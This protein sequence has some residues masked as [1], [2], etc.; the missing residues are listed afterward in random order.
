MRCSVLTVLALALLSATLPAQPA[1]YA[2]RGVRA[3]L[4]NYNAVH[5][6][7][8]LAEFAARRFVLID[9]A[10]SADIPMLRAIAPDIPILRYRDMV[11]VYPSLPEFDAVDRDE[12]AFMH[13]TE[14]SG[15]SVAISGDTAT[16]AWTP[17]RRSLPVKGYRLRSS[18]DSLGSAHALVDSLIT[19]VPLRVRLPKSTVFLRVDAELEDGSL[20]NYGFPVRWYNAQTPMVV[21]PSAVGESRSATA[22]ENHIEIRTSGSMRPDSVIVVADLDRSNTLNYSQ[23]R[24]PASWNGESWVCDFSVDI[25]GL[26]SNCGYEF[27]AETW[28]GGRRTV[29]PSQGKW[30]TNVNNRVKNDTYGFYVMNVGS[31]TWRQA[32]IAQI[33]L[34]FSRQGYSG[35]FEDDTWYRIEN[36]GGDSYPP[37]PYDQLEWRANLYGMLDSIRAAIAPR[38]AYF[39]GLYTDVSDSLLAHT[40]GGM[41]EGFAY[42]HWSG[43]VRGASW[44]N[45]CNRGLS[46][47]HVYRKTWMSLGGAPFDDISG[48]LYT[49]A[50]YLMVADSLSMFA[51]ATSYQE[52]SHFPEFDI[53]LGAPLESATLDVDTLAQV[54]GSGRYHRRE[55]EHGTV[56][57]NAGTTPVV[58]PD[59]RARI[60]ITALGGIT[61][62]GGRIEAIHES[63]TLAS[64]TARIYLNMDP[65]ETLASPV[66]DSTRVEPERIPSDGTT[67]CTIRVLAHDASAP[68][69]RSAAALPL[70]VVCDAGAIGGP[71]E[72]VLLPAS[73]GSPERPVWF[74]AAFTIP[75]G[76]PP[77]S[78]RLPVSV[79]AATG[80]VTIGYVTVSI[81]SGDPGNL[82]MNYSFEI[83]DNDDDVPDFWRGYSKGFDYDISGMH[84]RSGS[85]S[86]HVFNDSLT[87]FRGVYVRV[88]LK[89]DSAQA[90]EISGWSKCID[91]SGNADN[92]YALYVDSRYMDGTSLYGQCARFST[93]TH[94]WEYSSHVIH[95]EKPIDYCSVYV[96]F[97]HHTGETWFDQLALRRYDETSDIEIN[98]PET[99]QIE[100]YPNPARDVLN[101]RLRPASHA[102]RRI[103]LYDHL[104]RRC[105]EK[106]LEAITGVEHVSVFPL[107]ALPAGVYHLFV[108][109]RPARTVVVMR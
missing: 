27:T 100:A 48:R 17:D 45:S 66:I 88:D 108:D 4:V 107:T 34:A 37:V 61:T 80:L 105:V 8:F 54:N 53:P 3:Y 69:W 73:P 23:E 89:Q 6:D 98:G 67:P 38:P 50:S 44:R 49:L 78:A 46:A 14:P 9:E 83:D 12:A 55:F 29:Y 22:V 64:G 35:L 24:V 99:P 11:A 13:S 7:R 77:D 92:D 25:T 26:R 21:W 32:T 41:T 20:L 97:R 106:E 60:S 62:D 51:N 90:L 39:N 18:L 40:E 81:E 42:T 86:V 75:V 96:L 10:G 93:G 31:S 103:A 87:D 56:V 30:H 15:L 109:G 94:D 16:I 19:T 84:A 33:L 2:S 58:Y 74:E 63:D 28:S 85:R 57:V 43:L 79:Y 70:H 52:L 95:P 91:V 36:Y 76:A 1:G 71:R 82:L 102:V 59:S 72:L 47:A 5:G 101:I 68:R 104:G 65:D